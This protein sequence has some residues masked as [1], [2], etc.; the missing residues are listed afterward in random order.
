MAA[1]FNRFYH[2][3]PILTVDDPS[4]RQARLNLVAA[5][6]TVLGSAFGLICLRKPEKI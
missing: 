4:V 5:V 3:C 6:K 1:A 2:N